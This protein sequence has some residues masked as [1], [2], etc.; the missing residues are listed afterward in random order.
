M[1]QESIPDI[2]SLV[3][4]M[5]DSAKH[6]HLYFYLITKEDFHAEKHIY[7]TKWCLNRTHDK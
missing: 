2:H 6:F 1:L 4:S 7:S 3:V 5:A